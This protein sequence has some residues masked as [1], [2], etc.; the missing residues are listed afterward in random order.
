MITDRRSSHLFLLVGT[1]PLPVYVVASLLGNK[2]GFIYLVASPGVVNVAEHLRQQLSDFKKIEII[3][4]SNPYDDRLIKQRVRAYLRDLP[5]A[6]ND[7]VGLN[8]TGGTKPMSLH[9]H[10]VLQEWCNKRRLKYTLSYLDANELTLRFVDGVSEPVQP[11]DCPL[12]FGTLVQLHGWKNEA[13]KNKGPI[14]PDLSRTLANLLG[15]KSRLSEWRQ[16]CDWHLRTWS[17]RNRWLKE[18]WPAFKV[19]GQ[20]R[21]LLIWAEDS[22][23]HAAELELLLQWL[24]TSHRKQRKAELTELNLPPFLREHIASHTLSELRASVE[25]ETGWTDNNHGF[26]ELCDFLD[27]GWLESFALSCIQN[28]P[29]ADKIHEAWRSVIIQRSG[30]KSAEFEFDVVAM[31]GYQLFALSCTTSNQRYINK[32]KLLEAYTRAR[33]MGGDEARVGL[34]GGYHDAAGLLREVNEEWFAPRDM[35]RVF[36]VDDWPNLQ[37]ELQAWFNWQAM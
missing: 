6:S 12:S 3:T 27:G 19:S 11:D 28:L 7:S 29:D 17:G 23:Q 32:S 37:E 16:W 5:V 13:D 30:V 33:Q 2:D 35:I 10:E 18:E 20:A 14:L 21:E 9:V 31:K 36:G 34:V 4:L 15:N 22:R 25:T 8:Y 1:N 24:S 26:D